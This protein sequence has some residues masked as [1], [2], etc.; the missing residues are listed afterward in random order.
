MA[1]RHSSLTK[2]RRTI[3]N[4]LASHAR[5]RTT[6]VPGLAFAPL[7]H[8]GPVLVFASGEDRSPARHTAQG[9]PALCAIMQA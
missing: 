1:R 8:P 4:G 3:P 6:S 2:E 5:T 9:V 7:L